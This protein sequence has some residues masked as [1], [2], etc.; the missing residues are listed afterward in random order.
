MIVITSLL[1][2]WYAIFCDQEPD[3][4]H[5]IRLVHKE[6]RFLR[7]VSPVEPVVPEIVEEANEREEHLRSDEE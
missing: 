1:I 3:F 7:V 5:E 2:A 4:V 6:L